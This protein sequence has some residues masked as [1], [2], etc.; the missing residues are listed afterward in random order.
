[1]FV[2]EPVIKTLKRPLGRLRKLRSF[3]AL[4]E[5]LGHLC[6]LRPSKGFSDTFKTHES[7][8]KHHNHYWNVTPVNIPSTF[9]PLQ[10]FMLNSS[11]TPEILKP[12]NLKTELHVIWKSHFYPFSTRLDHSMRTEEWCHWKLLSGRDMNI[13]VKSCWETSWTSPRMLKTPGTPK[14]FSGICVLIKD[15][16]LLTSLLAQWMTSETPSRTFNPLQGQIHPTR[17]Q[18]SF[19]DHSLNEDSSEPLQTP[20]TSIHMSIAWMPAKT[21]SPQTFCSSTIGTC[22]RHPRTLGPLP[23]TNGS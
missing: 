23:E 12:Q 19:G 2:H 14:T 10:S 3:R 1:M 8:Y 15:A 18:E 6:D 5:L 13:E 22:M 7:S 9:K 11:E 21:F 16:G 4:T 17:Y 20:H